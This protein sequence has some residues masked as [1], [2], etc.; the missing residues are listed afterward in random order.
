MNSM[1]K[2]LNRRQER[3]IE[4]LLISK[5]IVDASKKV[6]VTERTI[7]RWLKDDRFQEVY[8]SVRH[9]IV[10]YA[11][12]NIQASIEKAVT[13]LCEIMAD[14]DATTSSR[15]SAAKAIIDNGLN[16]FELENLEARIQ[17]LEDSQSCRRT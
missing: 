14:P 6:G 3:A 9:Q 8:K 17:A 1:K 2:N 15:V 7:R 11:I 13:T 4:A 12:G 5:S 16:T 10:R